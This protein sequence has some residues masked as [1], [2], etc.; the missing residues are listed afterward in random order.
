MATVQDPYI[1]ANGNVVMRT[2]ETTPE[3][4]NEVALVAD[5]D[6]QVFDNVAAVARGTGAFAS[7][8]IRDAAIRNLARA[9]VILI[10]LQR[11]RLDGTN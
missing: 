8:T 3:E 1:D 6:G 4:D 10:R 9:I 2:R 7:A 5:L 11:R